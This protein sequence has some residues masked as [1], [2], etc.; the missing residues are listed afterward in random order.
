M[1]DTD[2]SE[3]IEMTYGTEPYKLHRSEALDTSVEAAHS[4]DTTALERMVHDYIKGCGP[5]GCIADDVLAAYAGYPYSSITARFSALIEKGLI[6]RT[7]ER[8]KG[9][10]G[11]GQSVMVAK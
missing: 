10:S 8:R 7:G 2:R 3:E 1:S 4:G 6:E 5:G 11:R 9:R